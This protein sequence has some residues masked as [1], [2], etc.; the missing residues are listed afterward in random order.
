MEIDSTPKKPLQNQPNLS[1]VRAALRS[2]VSF[3]KS[4]K[5]QEMGGY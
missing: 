1:V 2:D 3:Y 4:R 5:I